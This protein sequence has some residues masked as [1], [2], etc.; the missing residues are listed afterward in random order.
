MHADESDDRQR[1]R[2]TPRRRRAGEYGVSIDGGLRVE[3]KRVKART[4]AIVA[5]SRGGVESWMAG[6]KGATVYRGHARFVDEKVVQ[7][8]G[9][10][11]TSE[12]IFLDV[13]ARPQ[14][15][16]MDGLETVRYLT[17]VT[18]MEVDFIPEHLIVIGGSYVGLGV[19]T[20][21]AP[22]RLAASPSS[23]WAAAR[24]P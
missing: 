17:N 12:K 10:S 9:E 15:P 20:D 5:K 3:M 14:I 23:R 7:V 4:D 13:G 22:L 1:L 24:W 16:T 11:L 19:R 18:M 6:L 2:R 21:G 8:N